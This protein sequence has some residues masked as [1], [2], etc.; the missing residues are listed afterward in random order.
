MLVSSADVGRPAEGGDHALENLGRFARRDG[1]LDL[2]ARLVDGAGQPAEQQHLGGELHRHL[3]EAPL[4]AATG[5]VI[6]GVGHLDCVAR[7]RRQRL[8]HVGEQRTCRE[9]RAVGDEHEALGELSRIVGVVHERFAVSPDAGDV[10]R[11]EQVLE[12]P[13][14]ATFGEHRETSAIRRASPVIHQLADGHP[15]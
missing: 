8:V 12:V 9:A 6:D 11:R 10:Q 2:G 15:D 4:A 13:M 5:Q 1:L 7:S 14:G 3:V